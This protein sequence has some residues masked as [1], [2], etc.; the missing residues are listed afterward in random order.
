L[1][2]AEPVSLVVVTP[3]FQNPTGRTLGMDERREIVALAREHKVTLIENG[4]YS[5]L[6]YRGEALPALKQLDDSGSVVLV[7]S[8]SK[9]AFPG[10]RVGWVIAPSKIAGPITQAK[11]WADLHTDQLSQALLLR[12]AESGR[13]AAHLERVRA[14]GGERLNAVLAACE[15]YLPPGTKYTKP[16]GGMNLWIE[17]PGGVDAS[18]LLADMQKLGVNYLPGRHFSVSRYEPGTMRLSFGA[19]PPARIDSGVRALGRGI[20]ARM[21]QA[22]P[23]LV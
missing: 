13:M 10:L 23:A 18:D 2:A 7:G 17:L 12:F 14:H 1:L 6:R 16:Q 21:A 4:I 15:R 9:M 22:V 8:F 11:Q 3:D 20:E 19:L 5:K